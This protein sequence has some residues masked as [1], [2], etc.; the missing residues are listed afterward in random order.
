MS[1]SPTWITSILDSWTTLRA[2]LDARQDLVSLLQGTLALQDATGVIGTNSST[3]DPAITF[4][5]VAGNYSASVQGACAGAGCLAEASYYLLYLDA[6]ADSDGL[7]LPADN[8]PA[9]ANLNQSDTDRDDV[10]DTCDNCPLVFN[11]D[12][13]DSDGDGSGDACPPCNP[14]PEAATDLVFL[15]SQTLSW[16]SSPAA[17]AY[18]LYAGLIISGGFS[19]NHLCRAPNLQS[20]AATISEFPSPGQ[21]LYFLVSG[22]NTCG[23]GTLGLT[24]GGQPRPNQSPCP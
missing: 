1:P 4:P 8:C 23:E 16:S 15:N 10:G 20:P 11:P 13:F 2:D 24:S 5:L 3:P 9:V 6:D 12:Q 7:F 18:D 21:A 14:P 19:F 17:D 22:N